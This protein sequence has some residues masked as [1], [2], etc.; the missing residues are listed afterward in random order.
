MAL[1]LLV[2]LVLESGLE[3]ATRFSFRYL[4]DEAVIPR[5]YQRL[6]ELL[7]LLGSAAVLLAAV[8][9]IADYVWAKLGACVVSD[10]RSDLYMH[11]QTLSLDFSQRRKSGDLLNVLIAD[12]ETIESCLVTVVPYGL[13]GT[14]AS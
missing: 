2:S 8:S 4:I 10:L 7:G 3:S 11:V 14:T 9:I 6:I 12:P 1:A 5:N 13:L